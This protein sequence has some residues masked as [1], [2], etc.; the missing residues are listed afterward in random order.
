MRAGPMA[1][2]AAPSSSQDCMI[3]AMLRGAS[4]SAPRWSVVDET[5]K[6]TA[7]SRGTTSRPPAD[8]TA[9]KIA[10]SRKPRAAEGSSAR[11]LPLRGRGKSPPRYAGATAAVTVRASTSRPMRRSRRCPLMVIP[12]RRNA[13]RDAGS[14]R[15]SRSS[16]QE[17]AVDTSA[18]L[19]DE[20]GGPQLG[21][22]GT[23]AQHQGVLAGLHGQVAQVGG[24]EYGG[25]AGT[26]VGDHLE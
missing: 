8:A 26:R 13:S 12:E 5:G 21:H 16:V 3:H 6:A 24:D 18:L 10:S 1:Y 25:T 14:L 7:W 22:A 4:S 2:A 15:L 19:T 11:M 23:A 9:V 20:L 17:S